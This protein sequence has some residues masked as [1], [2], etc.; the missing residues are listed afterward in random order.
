M[1]MDGELPHEM[2]GL[3]RRGC[4]AEKYS[5]QR[6]WGFNAFM[7]VTVLQIGS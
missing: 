1:C 3:R 2:A 6:V 4:D 5:L 7:S